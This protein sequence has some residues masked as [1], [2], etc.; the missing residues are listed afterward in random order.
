[1]ILSTAAVEMTLTLTSASVGII[2][3]MEDPRQ[4]SKLI[5]CLLRLDRF[6]FPLWV[7]NWAVG[8]G[9]SSLGG[10]RLRRAVYLQEASQKGAGRLDGWLPGQGLRSDLRQ[11]SLGPQC[12]LGVG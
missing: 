3:T 7:I 9:G 12:V 11:G 2:I 6:L 4:L 10:N 1:M 8:D 5:S